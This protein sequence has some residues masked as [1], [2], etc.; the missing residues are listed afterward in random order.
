MK[1]GPG[2]VLMLHRQ[3][4]QIGVCFDRSEIFDTG[5]ELVLEVPCH[6]VFVLWNISLGL[7]DVVVRRGRLGLPIR[8]ES[9]SA[10]SL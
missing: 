4:H 10:A 7:A 2:K 1:Q 3:S 6:L 9:S 5:G 8:V